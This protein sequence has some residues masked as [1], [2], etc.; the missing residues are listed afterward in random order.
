[1]TGPRILGRR[2]PT[3]IL[4]GTLSLTAVCQSESGVAPALGPYLER[5]TWGG[6]NA[7][8]IV[9]ESA[10]HVHIGCTYGDIE[11]RVP[12]DSDGRFS[13]S[14]SY[15]LRAYPVA[16]GP[17]LP[18]TFHGQ[19]VRQRL[20]VTTLTLVVAVNDTVENTAR[21]LGPVTVTFGKEPMLG[22]CP[23]CRVPRKP[24]PG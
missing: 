23:I 8:T 12:L 18:A 9:T 19:V 11:G 20:G 15:V 14:G 13:L 1:M 4:A 24:F 10:T 5:G 6:E 2:A 16:V 17:P 7:G 3:W 22:P 21:I